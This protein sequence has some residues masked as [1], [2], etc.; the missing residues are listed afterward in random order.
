MKKFFGL[1]SIIIFG[2]YGCPYSDDIPSHLRIVNNSVSDIY[3]GISSS[4]PDTSLSHIEVIPFYEGNTTQKIEAGDTMSIRTIILAEDN[5]TQIFFFDANVVEA[6]SWDSI[7]S[8][9]VVLKRKEI[10][11]SDLEMSDWTITYP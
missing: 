7:V 1:F 3:F 5:T 2:L 10:T 9:Y 8:N 4:F 11:E 6:E